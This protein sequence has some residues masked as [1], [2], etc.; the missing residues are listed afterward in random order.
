MRSAGDGGADDSIF[1]DGTTSDTGLRRFCFSLSDPTIRF[2]QS[3]RTSMGGE[4]STKGN[5]SGKSNLR[6][7]RITPP[8]VAIHQITLLLATFGSNPEHY[9]KRSDQVANVGAEGDPLDV[10][11]VE[12]ESIAKVAA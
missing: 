7:C 12:P 10:L 9:A 1:R 4:I 5:N 2:P 6:C 8:I 11:G 3:C